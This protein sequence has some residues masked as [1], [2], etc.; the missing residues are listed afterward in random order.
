MG[1]SIDAVVVAVDGSPDGTAAAEFAAEL[2]ARWRSALYLVCVAPTAPAAAEAPS[3][4][5]LRR[6]LL[7]PLAPL[8][9]QRTSSLTAIGDDAATA[10]QRLAQTG[11]TLADTR[12]HLE[13]L[14]R[15][16]ARL[17]TATRCG[18]V[19]RQ[20]VAYAGEVDADVIVVGRRGAGGAR[21][22]LGSVS[23]KVTDLAHCTC[24]VVR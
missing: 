11:Q 23:R 3:G 16:P 10:Q 4:L 12:R 14:D 21:P 5:G 6:R 1:L 18:P 19:A 17:H 13:R 8:F 7:G 2:A 24:I 15:A 20:I 22:P 9:T